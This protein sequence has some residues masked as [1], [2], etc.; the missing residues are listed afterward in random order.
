MDWRAELANLGIP[1]A[2]S[3]DINALILSGAILA[4]SVGVGWLTQRYPGKRLCERIAA[5]EG[6][7]SGETA[8]LVRTA[9]ALAAAA[10]IRP[11]IER[12][13]GRRRSVWSISTSTFP[14]SGRTQLVG[15]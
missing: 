15:R 12:F 4:L 11:T 5:L 1:V 8:G 7:R 2:T 14:T 6:E 3:P 9:L 10:L 13:S